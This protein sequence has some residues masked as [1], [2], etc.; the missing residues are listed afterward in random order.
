MPMPSKEE[1][2]AVLE[3]FHPKIRGVVVNAWEEWRIVCKLR[4]D[5]G[6][7][8]VLYSRTVSNDVFDAI[9]RG[10]IAAFIDEPGVNL[11]I[12]TQTFKLFFKGKVCARFKRGNE[13]KLGQNI[14]T[15]AAL[16]FEDP[17][18]ELAGFPSHT[19]K[20]EIIWLANDLNTRLESV[21]VVAR[22]G[23]RLIWEYEIDDNSAGGA[24]S[25]FTFPTPPAPP[26]PPAD[27]DDNLITPKAPGTK[28]TGEGE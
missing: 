6:L 21:S 22:D 13:S 18:G 20:V 23:D 7:A 4:A 26:A 9:A 16:A 12:E 15:Q 14:P 3:P 8:P 5:N 24:G 11:K 27:D 19:A 2:H 28:K 1:V 10:G 17:E 25:V